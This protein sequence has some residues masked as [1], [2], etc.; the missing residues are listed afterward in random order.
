MG[1]SRPSPVIGT[2]SFHI[3]RLVASC[4]F[5]RYRL[6]VAVVLRRRGKR[7]G[8]KTSKGVTSRSLNFELW[9]FSRKKRKI[10]S[11]KK[12]N[13]NRGE[14]LSPFF[15]RIPFHTEEGGGGISITRETCNILN[16]N[17]LVGEEGDAHE[18][19]VSPFGVSKLNA[20]AAQFVC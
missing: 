11:R 12:G 16:R 4:M 13:I 8:V 19:D 15:G 3:S 7:K 9:Y 20:L 6:K 18:H 5:H 14:K 10:S 17:I 1:D 2:R